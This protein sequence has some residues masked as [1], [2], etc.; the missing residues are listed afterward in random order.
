MH[1]VD[2]NL[3]QATFEGICQDEDVPGNWAWYSKIGHAVA[4]MCN[5]GGINPC[6]FGEF[7]EA[8]GLVDNQCNDHN[9]FGAG[10]VLIQDWKKGYGRSVTGYGICSWGQIIN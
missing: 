9:G 3:A 2:Y 7:Q 4:Y 6:R 1:Q 8:M 10:W 5:Y